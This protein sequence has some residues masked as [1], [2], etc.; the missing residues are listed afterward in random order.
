MKNFN[1]EK[2]TLSSE[3]EFQ[4]VLAESNQLDDISDLWYFV[5]SKAGRWIAGSAH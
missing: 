3:F 1:E 4:D 2:Q 5:H